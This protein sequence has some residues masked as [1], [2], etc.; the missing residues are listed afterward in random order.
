MRTTAHRYFALAGKGL[1]LKGFT[2]FIDRT[3]DSSVVDYLAVVGWV[4][5][6]GW[7]ALPG[8]THRNAY[9]ISITQLVD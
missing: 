6:G 5:M 1:M 9:R 8:S 2:A 4:S 7:C 3:G